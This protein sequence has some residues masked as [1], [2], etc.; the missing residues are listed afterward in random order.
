VVRDLLERFPQPD[1]RALLVWLPMVKGDDERAAQ[2]AAARLA[3]GRVLHFWDPELRLGRLFAATLGLPRPAWD[4]YLLYAEGTA[5]S[6]ARPPPP[7]FWMHQLYDGPAGLELDPEEMAR[8][9]EE[10]LR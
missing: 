4:V 7:A 3:D 10:M 9:L 1:L 8:R 6:D 5:W 2:V